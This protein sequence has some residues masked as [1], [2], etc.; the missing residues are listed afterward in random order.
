MAG[1]LLDVPK[2]AAGFGDL[3]GRSGDEGPPAA[4]AAGTFQTEF[5]I[6]PVEP[7]GD[8]GG[9]ITAAPFRS[10]SG[11]GCFLRLIN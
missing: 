10:S 3:P 1:E 8:R 11:D 4:V 9:T 7:H 2:R 6:D 5:L